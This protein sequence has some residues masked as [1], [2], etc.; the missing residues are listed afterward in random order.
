MNLTPLKQK[1]FEIVT[2]EE[3]YAYIFLSRRDELDLQYTVMSNG[4]IHLT[5][6]PL[7]E[8]ELCSD[9]F[10]GNVNSAEQAMVLYDTINAINILQ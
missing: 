6:Y 2:G 3:T 1:G 9:V 4:D 7:N 8:D 10:V 5:E